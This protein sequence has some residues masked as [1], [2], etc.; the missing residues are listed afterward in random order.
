MLAIIH[1]HSKMHGPYNIK[2][3]RRLGSNISTYLVRCPLFLRVVMSET[4]SF[5]S[6]SQYTE[7]LLF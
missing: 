1:F 7:R 3:S 2:F 5:A 4:L 6:Q